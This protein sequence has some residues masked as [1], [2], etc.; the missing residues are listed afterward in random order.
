VAPSPDLD[1]SYR[2]DWDKL[3]HRRHP[4]DGVVIDGDDTTRIMRVVDTPAGAKPAVLYTA[5]YDA[6]GSH[7]QAAMKAK[8]D[9][10]M[11]NLRVTEH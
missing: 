9:L 1:D 8:L 4:Y 6:E 5:Y 7:P 2:S 3:L 11:Q 10:L